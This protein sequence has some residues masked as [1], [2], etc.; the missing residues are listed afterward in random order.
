MKNFALY[1]LKGNKIKT[2]KTNFLVKINLNRNYFQWDLNI[3][4][5]EKKNF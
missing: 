2:I 5:T 3:V 4:K 1:V